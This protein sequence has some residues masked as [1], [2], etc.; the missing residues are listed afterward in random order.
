MANGAGLAERVANMVSHR[1][2]FKTWDD[3]NPWLARFFV[4]RQTPGKLRMP[5]QEGVST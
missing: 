2:N 3:L 1:F 5:S 4:K